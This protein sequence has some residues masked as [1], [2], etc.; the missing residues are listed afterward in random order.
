VISVS[1][2]CLRVKLLT[3]EVAAFHRT[4]AQ[5]WE[6]AGSAAM[7]LDAG[8]AGAEDWT[9]L[10][11]RDEAPM[12]AQDGPSSFLDRLK[13]RK[14]VQWTAAYLSR[15]LADCLGDRLGDRR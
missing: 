10:P 12:D 5:R 8:P 4:V 7:S 14:V 2:V 3:F 9:D 1:S 11:A 15:R 13:R 6:A